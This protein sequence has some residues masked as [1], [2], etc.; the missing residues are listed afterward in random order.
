MS[1]DRSLSDFLGIGVAA[2]AILI[3]FGAIG[4]VVDVGLGSL[5]VFVFVGLAVGIA[6]AIAFIYSRFRDELRGPG[7][8][9]STSGTS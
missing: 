8:P 4:F 2:A 1:D 9:H 6:A 3:G 7:S 5:P